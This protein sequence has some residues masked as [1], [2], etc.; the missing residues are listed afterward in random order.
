MNVMKTKILLAVFSF[1]LFFKLHAQ[2]CK[3][4]FYAFEQGGVHKMQHLSAKGDVMMTT[5]QT[6]K[7]IKNS[8][9]GVTATILSE[10]F[11]KKDKKQGE[12]TLQITCDAGVVKFDMRNMA[13]QNM[14]P[15]MS[16]QNNVNMEISGDQIDMPSSLEVGST[17]K[18]ITYT[19]KMTM[20][21]MTM[22]NK[23]T[24]IRERKVESKENI[25]V[26][27]G[28]FECYKISYLTDFEGMFGKKNTMKTYTWYA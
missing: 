25:T 4:S 7:E 9:N 18:N 1:C 17:L 2:D 11:D 19:M 16:K 13:M 10:S 20:G 26:P 6:C 3:D 21:S 14:P 23:E 15:E 22:M 24:T 8:T 28:T 27:A 12:V 5:L